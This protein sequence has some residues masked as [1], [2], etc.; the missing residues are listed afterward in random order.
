LIGFID[1]N[2]NIKNPLK[3]LLHKFNTLT[4]K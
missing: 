1:V 3:T 2:V 4:I